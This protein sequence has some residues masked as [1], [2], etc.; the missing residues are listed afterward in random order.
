MAKT[1]KTDKQPD[2]YISAINING[3]E[4]RMLHLPAPSATYNKEILFIY[5]HHSSIE[6]WWGLAQAFNQYGP[7]TVPDLPGF[8]GMD[9]TYKI[10]KAATIDNLADYLA[11]FV[12][13]RYKRRRLV[14]VGLS[15]G[16][17][18]VTRMLQK[19]PDLAKKVDF[20]VSAAGFAHKDDFRMPP[21][22]KMFLTSVCAI[23][24]N[25]VMA[26]VL[27]FFVS[28]K[29]ILKIM[30]GKSKNDKYV[31]VTDDTLFDKMMDMETTL[32]RIN[33]S[34][35]QAKTTFEMFNLDNCQ[36]KIDLPVWHVYS[37]HDNYFD[38]TLVEQHY[39]IIFSSYNDAA[40]QDLKHSPSV[41]A[42]VEESSV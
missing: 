19:N 40:A 36:K 35:T 8:G 17:T 9:P 2:D 1:A 15:F 6:R 38:N 13:M 3:L 16:F 28:R 12:R 18:V 32:W 41:I 30:Y 42:T 25:P 33:D 26:K 34:R 14:I 31:D 24:L 39:R 23:A 7:V 20:L 22:K 4:G 5:G 21:K 11:S 37:P 29:F 10:G 27:H